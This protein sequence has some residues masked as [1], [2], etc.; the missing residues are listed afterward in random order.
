MSTVSLTDEQQRYLDHLRVQ[1]RLAE[2]TLTLYT[3]ALQRLTG[4]ASAQGLDLL[5]L[6]AHQARR[7]LA[8]L[9]AD[10]LKPRTLA[11]ILSAWRG[12]Y[13]WLGALALAGFTVLAALLAD[14]HA[15]LL[16]GRWE[17]HL[18]K[19]QRGLQ[20]AFQFAQFVI[21]VNAQRLEGAGGRMNGQT[22]RRGALRLRDNGGELGG[23]VRSLLSIGNIRNQPDDATTVFGVHRRRQCD[24]TPAG[25]AFVGVVADGKLVST[26]LAGKGSFYVCAKVGFVHAGPYLAHMPA[27]HGVGAKAKH[28][29]VRFV[30]EDVP[31]IKRHQHHAQVSVPCQHIQ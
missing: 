21:H 2:R 15:R 11:L 8:T 12:W 17:E 28:A 4:F 18:S 10:R 19:L 6:S 29:A 5:R 25:S 27:G 9:H 22:Q 1:R 7:F 3:N 20:A 14:T 26:T 30:H 13:R 16:D 23:H 24:F 31:M